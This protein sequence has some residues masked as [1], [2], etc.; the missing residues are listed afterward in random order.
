[1]NHGW[2]VAKR[3]NPGSCP[4]ND[5]Q[6]GPV[7]KRGDKGERGPRG[8]PGPSGENALE[9]VGV[10]IDPS[11]YTLVA[12]MSDGSEGPAILLRPLLEQYD[13]ERKGAQ[14]GQPAKEPQR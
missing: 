8:L 12:V 3:D 1:M 14:H 7:G 5:W 9:W 10:K 4:G 6:S 13:E 11:A 2:F